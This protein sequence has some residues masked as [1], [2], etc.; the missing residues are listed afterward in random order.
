MN[1]KS[2]Y[3]QIS[4]IFG[5]LITSFFPKTPNFGWMGALQPVEKFLETN[6]SEVVIPVLR[7]LLPLEKLN[8]ILLGNTWIAN[9]LVYGVFVG[10][11]FYFI[12]YSNKK[13]ITVLLFM[14][15]PLFWVSSDGGIV[16][17]ISFIF[18]FIAILH[19]T[20]IIINNN[21]VKYRHLVLLG[22][23]L[24]LADLSRPFFLPFVLVYFLILSIYLYEKNLLVLK[25]VKIKA[26]LIPLGVFLVL[27][28]PFH[29][30][31]YKNTNSLILSNWGGCNLSE[32]FSEPSQIPFDRALINT[33]TYTNECNRMKD[34]IL[35]KISANP[36]MLLLDGKILS[37]F[38]HIFYPPLSYH[39]NSKFTTE[40]RAYFVE[41]FYLGITVIY[42]LFI[43]LVAINL[44]RKD[45]TTFIVVF[46]LIFYILIN[47]YTHGGSEQIRMS[48][49]I[50][51]IMLYYVS[52]SKG[53]SINRIR[54]T[55][56]NFTN[57]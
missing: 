44:T 6:L 41:F 18:A 4:L 5:I 24:S 50:I 10:L 35:K 49:P 52:Q 40:I 7:P 51:V 42:L 19:L 14:V 32:V 9:N 47:T 3:F 39:G 12:L 1:T 21:G 36:S 20:N 53:V 13:Y 33:E 31:Q 16:Y 2:V 8:Y 30:L 29:I 28:S 46:Y 25:H 37:K 57:R 56:F 55:L 34:N 48:Y 22:L 15:L 38:K 45:I 23:V 54:E 17:D 43:Y 26:L 11:V 27:S